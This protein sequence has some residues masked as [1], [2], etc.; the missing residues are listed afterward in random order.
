MASSLVATY[1]LPLIL[2]YIW[3]TKSQSSSNNAATSTTALPGCNASQKP[4]G[5][6]F[7]DSSLGSDELK[8]LDFV[9]LATVDGR[10]HGLNRT[11]GRM[12]WSMDEPVGNSQEVGTNLK[13][14]VSSEHAGLRKANDFFLD[15]LD[16]PA[17]TETYIIEPQSGVIFVS[18][19]DGKREGPLHRLPFTMQQLVDMSPFRMDHRTFV[20]RKRTS[21]ITL[22]LASGELVEA[23]EPEQQCKEA[24]VKVDR[25]EYHVSVFSSGQVTQN[26]TYASYGSKGIDK[27]M[28]YHWRRTPDNFYHQSTPDGTLLMF[29]TDEKEP[30]HSFINLKHPV[31]AV[32]DAV[33]IAERSDP[34]LLSQ[35][36]PALSDLYPSRPRELRELSKQDEITWVGRVGDSLYA[37]SQTTF[38][39]VVFS[40]LPKLPTEIHEIDDLGDGLKMAC[41]SLNCLTGPHRTEAATMSMFE[42]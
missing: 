22:D 21:V 36:K 37:L 17:S 1:F 27:E 5:L 15:D 11:T 28:Q 8:L 7:R 19:A 33:S 23:L 32:F 34:L 2:F 30:F 3:A 25:T 29:K 4:R 12:L 13:Q 14:L 40:Q 18:P 31:V 42:S 35:P 26:L 9:L 24:F 39:L 38:P 20:G 6:S 41:T 16:D 10:F